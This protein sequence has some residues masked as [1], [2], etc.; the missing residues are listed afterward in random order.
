[1]VQ[2][3]KDPECL[4]NLISMQTANGLNPNEKHRRHK[5]HNNVQIIKDSESLYN[6]IPMRTATKNLQTE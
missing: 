4:H 6:L 3:I 5:S 1:M 2:L